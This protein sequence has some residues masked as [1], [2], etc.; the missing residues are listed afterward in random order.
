MY[1]ALYPQYRQNI[2]LEISD[3]AGSKRCGIRKFGRQK[4]ISSILPKAG[5][6]HLIF[7]SGIF[8]S[9]LVQYF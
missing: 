1:T 8:F 5:D 2:Q 4:W 6:V 3:S 9:T 7:D